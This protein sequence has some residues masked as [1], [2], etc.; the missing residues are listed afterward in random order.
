MEKENKPVA[1]ILSVYKK[2]NPK[3][4]RLAIDSIRNQTYDNLKLYIGV[5]GRVGAD[6]K[7]TMDEITASDS[8]LETIYFDENRGLAVVLNDV[9][10]LAFENGYE[11]IAR[12]DADDISL[13]ERF[14]KQVEYLENHPDIDVVGGAIS[15]IDEEGSSRNK[16]IEYPDTP[17][18]CRRFFA[19]RNPHAHPAVMFRKSFFDKIGHGYRPEYRQNQDVMLWL[20]GFTHKSRNANI[21]DVILNFRITDSFFIRRGNATKFAKKQLQDRLMINKTLNYGIVSYIY[22]YAMYIL[23]ISPSWV[24]KLAYKIFR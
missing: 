10:K 21:P 18:D 6:L 14:A 1:V 2:D 19:R 5:D 24:L 20:D 16:V 15:E 23:Q 4:V 17:E 22:G 12:M 11:L 9:L 3:Y 7:K 13:P 8:R